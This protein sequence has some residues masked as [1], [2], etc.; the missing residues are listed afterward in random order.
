MLWTQYITMWSRTPSLWIGRKSPVKKSVQIDFDQMRALWGIF[1]GQYSAILPFLSNPTTP[2][3]TTSRS[4]HLFEQSP[5]EKVF[6]TLGLSIKQKAINKYTH[7]L[8]SRCLIVLMVMIAVVVIVRGS[9]LCKDIFGLR[10][11]SGDVVVVV[12]KSFA[13]MWWWWWLSPDTRVGDICKDVLGRGDIMILV[14][15]MLQLVSFAKIRMWMWWWLS[16]E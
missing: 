15:V 4:S 10:S 16:S 14:V 9:V 12:A 6:L 11:D 5:F 3:Q 1:W 7:M 2:L 8:F 13:K